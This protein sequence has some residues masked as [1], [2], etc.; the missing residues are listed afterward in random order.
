[1]TSTRY[2]LINLSFKPKLFKTILLSYIKSKIGLRLEKGK[3][4]L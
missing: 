2:T 1:M 3:L 4:S